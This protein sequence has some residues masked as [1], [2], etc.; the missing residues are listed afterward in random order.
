MVL[1]ILAERWTEAA[2][3]RDL[4]EALASRTMTMMVT[5]QQK[6]QETATS[7]SMALIPWQD[8][9]PEDLSQWMAGITDSGMSLGAD[10][11][12]SGLIDDFRTLE[13]E[14]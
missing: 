2:P 7:T 4:F 9:F 10:W 11:L 12:L 14:R 3:F 6:E 1:V 5:R 8:Q 13:P